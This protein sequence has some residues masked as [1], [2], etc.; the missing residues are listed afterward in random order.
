MGKR[1]DWV[2]QCIAWTL[3]YARASSGTRQRLKRVA[4]KEIVLED[5]PFP[6]LTYGFCMA[7][8]STLF[9]FPA[10]AIRIKLLNKPPGLLNLF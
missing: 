4:G 8:S 9:G 2:S 7:S 10:F 6:Y 1:S 5:L 3:V